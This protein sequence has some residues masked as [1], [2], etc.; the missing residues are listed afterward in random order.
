MLCTQKFL[1]V[2]SRSNRPNSS[3]E[4]KT[5][6]INYTFLAT[7]SSSSNFDHCFA[8]N[9]NIKLARSV[10]GIGASNYSLERWIAL[11]PCLKLSDIIII[12]HKYTPLSK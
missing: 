10:A 9:G 11:L 8:C 4:S 6:C 7:D 1:P 12:S 5:V 2:M 3:M